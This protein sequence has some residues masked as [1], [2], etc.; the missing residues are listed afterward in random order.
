VDSTHRTRRNSTILNLAAGLVLCG[1]VDWSTA[2]DVTGQRLVAVVI[3]VAVIG[4]GG[5][6]M[7]E[8]EPRVHKDSPDVLGL[9]RSFTGEEIEQA[10]R[11][12]R[13]SI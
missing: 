10:E 12:L 11:E 1:G 8:N 13:V 7:I 9:D 3:L 2:L 5:Q 4:L 6:R